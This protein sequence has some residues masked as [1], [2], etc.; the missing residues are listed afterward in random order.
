MKNPTSTWT[1]LA[2]AQKAGVVAA[3]VVLAVAG[4]TGVVLAVTGDPAPPAATPAQQPAVSAPAAAAT[5]APAPAP[6][7]GKSPGVQKRKVTETEPIKFTKRTVKDNWLPKGAREPRTAGIDGVRTKTYEVTLV[8]GRE[9]KRKLLKS[10]V[11]REPVPEV[12]AIG[13][14]TGPDDNANG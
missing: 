1:R 11:T 14:N 3:A 13:T 6:A 10:E 7:A 12:V 9:T 5:S 2:T 4:V 8:D